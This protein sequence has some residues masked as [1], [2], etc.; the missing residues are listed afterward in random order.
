MKIIGLIL[1]WLAAVAAP[2]QTNQSWKICRNPVRVFPGQATVD[3]TPLFQWWA[4][5]PLIIT[6]HSSTANTNTDTSLEPEARPLSAWHRVTGV[7]VGVIGSSWVVDAAIYSSPT[8]H[9]NARIILNHPPEAEEQAYYALEMQAAEA[10]QQIADT[11]R[12]YGA[13]TN[14][15]SKANKLVQ[16]FE[17]SRSKLRNDAVR[18]YSAVAVQ[19][20]AAAT[21]ALTQKAQ[22]EAARAEIEEKLRTIPAI[23]G[24][25]Q[26][27]WFAVLL[28]HSKQGVPIY[29]MGLV[30]ATPP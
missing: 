19:E 20:Q 11:Q 4:R 22:L 14:K 15:E 7:K 21:S 13:D 3:L 17:H 25:Y 28:G 16:A 26:V 12:I 9:T 10:K 1:F 2:A 24:A 27:D 8:V 23:K 5:Q 30:S 18:D 6:N 29:D